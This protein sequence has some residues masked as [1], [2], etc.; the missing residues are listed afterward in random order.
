MCHLYPRVTDENQASVAQPFHL[1][2]YLFRP[3]HGSGIPQPFENFL[4]K[5]KLPQTL[6]LQFFEISK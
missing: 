2:A 4:I 1:F 5:I 3:I 6:I